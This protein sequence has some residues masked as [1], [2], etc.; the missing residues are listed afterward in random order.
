MRLSRLSRV[1]VALGIG[2]VMPVAL[3]LAVR[4]PWQD[5]RKVLSTPVPGSRHVIELWEKPYWLFGQGYEYET[6]L[7]V[8]SD[9]GGESRYLIDEQYITFREVTILL[10][11]DGNRIRVET[12]GAAAVPHMIAEYD[13]AD[14]RFRAASEPTV[15]NTQGWVVLAEERI[16]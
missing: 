2:A 8:R 1:A 5:L 6:W 15:R 13:F 16:H 10:S 14:S 3:L 11:S 7:V 4:Q 12:D 9:D